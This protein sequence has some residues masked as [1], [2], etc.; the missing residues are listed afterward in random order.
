MNLES[1]FDLPLEPERNELDAGPRYQFSPNRRGFLKVLGGGIVVGLVL[2]DSLALA[3]PGSRRGR[4][5]GGSMPQDLAA[6][7]HINET[8]QV[9]V[10]TG[11]VELG[12]NIRTSLSQ[13]VAEELRLA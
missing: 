13:V 10:Y 6:W 7:L 4:G 1:H 12:Q 5:F 2:G 9:A 3:Q 8:G 11:K